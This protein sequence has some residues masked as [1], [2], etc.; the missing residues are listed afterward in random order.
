MTPP[1]NP[2]DITKDAKQ[3]AIICC[4]E[5]L[6]ELDKAMFVSEKIKFWNKVKLKIEKL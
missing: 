3:C 4:D 2:D 6:K 5:I 1:R